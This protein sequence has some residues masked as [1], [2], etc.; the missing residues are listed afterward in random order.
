M[1]DRYLLVDGYNIIFAWNNLKEIAEDNLDDA[2]E[3]LLNIMSNYKGYKNIEVIVVFDAHKVKGSVRTIYEYNNI[4]VV[5]TKE[6]ELADHYIERV[7]HI[8]GKDN[9]VKVATSDALEQTIILSKGATRMS[10]REL[11][12]EIDLMKKKIRNT[13]I[14]KVPVKNNT[15]ASN[16]SPEIANLM[17]KMRR[18]K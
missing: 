4:S 6:A 11:K 13:Y 17:E 14:N 9:E 10:A 15:F 16:L 7:A 12:M 1:Q 3:K 5:Y 2:R 18:Q 8:F